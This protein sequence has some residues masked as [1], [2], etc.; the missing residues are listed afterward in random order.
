MTLHVETRIVII[1]AR[2]IA[3]RVF[4]PIA[5][6]APARGTDDGEVGGDEEEEE[7]G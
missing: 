7:L 4:F 6:T 3:T 1:I 5:M 2:N